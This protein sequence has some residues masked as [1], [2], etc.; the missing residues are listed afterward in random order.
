[1]LALGR[2]KGVGVQALR[3]LLEAYP[4]LRHVWDDDLQGIRDV[5]ARARVTRSESIA[6][7]IKSQRRRLLDEGERERKALERREV[8]VISDRSPSFPKRLLEIPDRPFWLFVQGDASVLNGPPLVAIVGTRDATP[9][10][11]AVAKRLAALVV[12]Q[13]LNVV[14]GLAE[15][16][17]AA[18]HEVAA[19]YRVPQVGV[20]GTGV[21]GDFPSS[22]V[23]LRRRIVDVGGAIITEYL[24]NESYGRSHFVQRNRIQAGVASAVCP[25][26][27][28][29]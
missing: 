17:D 5:L 2:V 21:N 27:G 1:L 28:R 29:V 6:K 19:F 7:A 22:T 8:R 10:G 12:M 24:P 11:R 15:G 25:V 3:A 20:L 23:D 18:A 9:A 26:E 13:G 4:E 16:I 14:S